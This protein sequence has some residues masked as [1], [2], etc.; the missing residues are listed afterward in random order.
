MQR[1][2][3]NFPPTLG[4]WLTTSPS[5]KLSP[6]S[7]ASVAAS[8]PHHSSAAPSAPPSSA[9]T[10]SLNFSQ[11]YV[12]SPCFKKNKNKSLFSQLDFVSKTPALCRTGRSRHSPGCSGQW[13]GCGAGSGEAGPWC[14]PHQGQLRG[15]SHG[16]PSGQVSGSLFGKPSQDAMIPKAVPSAR[17]PDSLRR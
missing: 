13:T 6:L 3:L 9:Q 16:T 12:C 8:T 14:L 11:Q 7:G 15:F 4:P 2:C 10:A 1:K 17:C 5:H